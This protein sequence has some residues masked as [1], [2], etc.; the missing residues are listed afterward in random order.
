MN[1]YFYRN[2]ADGKIQWEFPQPDVV[3][4]NDEMEI[5]TT[6]PHESENGYSFPFEGQVGAAEA[7][8]NHQTTVG[9]CV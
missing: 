8:W 4:L 1:R 9:I 3:H 5:S 7:G 2:L 6:P